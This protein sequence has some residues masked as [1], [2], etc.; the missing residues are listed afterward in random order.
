[1]AG[2]KIFLD[3]FKFI[4]SSKGYA[5]TSFHILYLSSI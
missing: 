2:P 4:F 1:M 3:P 5:V